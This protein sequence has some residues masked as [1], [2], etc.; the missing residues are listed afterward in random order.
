METTR[1]GEIAADHD[2]AIGQH[3]D[4]VYQSIEIGVGG[5][6]RINGPRATQTHEVR[7]PCSVEVGEVS[8]GEHAVTRV[9][10]KI[11]NQTIG[12]SGSRIEGGVHDPILAYPRQTGASR[13]VDSRETAGEH[14]AIRAIDRNSTH[15]TTRNRKRLIRCIDDVAEGR[16][17]NRTIALETGKTAIRNASEIT[18]SPNFA[19]RA[20]D[21]CR[22]R[23]IK[24]RGKIIRPGREREI[25]L[26][27]GVEAGDIHPRFAVHPVKITCNV[28]FS[29]ATVR[30]RSH[31]RVALEALVTVETVIRP[32]G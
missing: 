4:A 19:I 22:N 32:A 5:K 9:H 28:V 8:R 12:N 10:G 7:L 18:E 2:F 3:F 27:V 29:V 31:R 1:G 26:S 20:F 13:A 11:S 23:T 16:E 15:R 6:S 30:D 25:D 17:S 21:H 24:V 14:H